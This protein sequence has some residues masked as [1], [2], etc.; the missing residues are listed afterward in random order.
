MQ[1]PRLESL[2]QEQHIGA[3]AWPDSCGQAAGLLHTSE[4]RN[5]PS[6]T[7]HSFCC[8]PHLLLS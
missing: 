4:A 3:A 2:M 1:L 8:L 6:P 5:T 7:H